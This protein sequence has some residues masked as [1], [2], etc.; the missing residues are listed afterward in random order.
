MSM[1]ITAGKTAR[2]EGQ[3]GLSLIETMVAAVVLLVGF[4]AT[5]SLFTVAVVQNST[6]GDQGTRVTEYAQDKMEQLM[7]LS[8]SDGATNTT[9]YPPASSG[10]TG[11]GGTMA[12]SATV[13]SVNSA[14]P[15]TGYVDYLDRNGALLTS[16]TGSFYKREWSVQTNAG[17]T[18]KTITVY[19]WTSSQLRDQGPPPTTTLVCTK[20]SE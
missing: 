2:F 5:M 9:V 7:A 19:V 1:T 12:G 6:Q 8:F 4:V 17:A 14:S 15:S 11:L 3:R 16:S 13:G 18:L 10:G 20:S